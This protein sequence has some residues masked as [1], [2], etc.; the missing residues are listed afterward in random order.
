[1]LKQAKENKIIRLDKKQAF[2]SIVRQVTINR[3][4]SDF[5]NNVIDLVDELTNDITVYLLECLPN[6][7]AVNL[8]EEYIKGDLKNESK[9]N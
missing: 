5:Y 9:D 4:N 6:E 1:M 7:G 8:L 2:R 3:W